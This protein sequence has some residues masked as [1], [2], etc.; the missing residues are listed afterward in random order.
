ML[1]G[2][3]AVSSIEQAVSRVRA[4][5]GRLDGALRSAMDE[6]ARLRREEAEGFRALARVKLDAMMRDQVIGDLDATERRALAMMENHRAALDGLTRR[7]TEAQAALDKA[8]A[9]KH[10]CDQVLADALGVLDELRNRTAAAMRDDGAWKAARAAVDAAAKVAAN[11]DQKASQAEADLAA[12]GQPYEADPLFMYLWRKR[13]GQAEDRSGRF[14][15]AIDRKVARLVGYQDARANYA[16]LKE[17]PVRLREHARVRQAEATAAAEQ[18]GMLERKALVAN[19]IEALEAKARAALDAVKAREQAIVKITA[20]LAAIEAERHK[21]LGVDSEA[22]YGSAVE[23]LAQGLAREDLRQLYREAART[24]TP[25]DDQAL[26]TISG[27]R[28]ACEK[29]DGEIVQIRQ[30]IRDMAQRRTELEGAR[31]RARSSGY[32]DPRGTFGGGQDVL[33][34]VIGG[35]LGGMLKGGALDSIFR[36]NYRAPPRQHQQ[37][38]DFGRQADTP[39]STGP[40]GGGHS[41]SWGGG[42]SNSENKDDGRSGWRTGGSF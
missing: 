36:D 25:A 7:R 21:A 13:H 22:T 35:I 19:G 42:T 18:L 9:A 27:A 5:E 32:D 15:R 38:H 16:M 6:A 31:D 29:V 24:P 37:D 26:S 3:D 12:K 30:E 40:W 8:E 23:L 14:V 10:D 11:A 2:R 20:D 33:G 17:I 39:A 4:D 1:T 34:Q 41:D 28:L